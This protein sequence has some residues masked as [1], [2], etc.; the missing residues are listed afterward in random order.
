MN[1]LSTIVVPEQRN[2]RITRLSETL[3]TLKTEFIGL[4]SIIDQIGEAIS[5]WYITP[6]I[7]SRPVVVSLWGMTG[8][9]KSSVVHRL[10]ELL[11]LGN[12]AM[13]FDCGQCAN[14]NKDI[15]NMICQTLGLEDDDASK[16]DR[17]F[18]TFV[19]D[20]FQYAR[21]IDEEGHE[22]L[23]PSLRP[24]WALLDSGIID[25]TDQY[26][27]EFVRLCEF[28]EDLEPITVQYPQIRVKGNRV[29]DP[30][31]VKIILETM[32]FLHYSGREIPGILTENEEFSECYG[33]G[34]KNDDDERPN[35]YRPLDLLDQ[36]CLRAIVKKM[37]EV[38]LGSGQAVAKQIFSNDWTISELFQ[39]LADIRNSVAR[40]KK[41]DCHKAL[42]FVIGNLDEAFQV[43]DDTNP[44]LD[45][46]MFY[47]ITN[48]VTIS[49]MKNALAQRFR[50]E[51][52]ARLGNNLIKYP[53]LQKSSFQKIIKKEV[54]RI[55]EEF[56]K[57]SGLKFNVETNL[58]DLLYAEGV[59]PTQG[60]R[61]IFTTITSILTPYLSKILLEMKPE[62]KEVVIFIDPTDEALKKDFKV[63]KVRIAIK[64]DKD[65]GQTHIYTHN[66][67]LGALRNP[68]SRRKRYICSVHEAGHAIAFAWRTGNAPSNIIS[69]STDHG[70]FC[71]TYD[72]EKEGEI[73][74]RR[75]IDNNTIIS[76]AGYL[77][78]KVIYGDR[79]E[80]CLLG[81]SADI[82][83]FWQDFSTAAYSIGYFK[84]FAFV[85]GNVES[86]PTN[87]L[88]ISNINEQIVNY[89]DGTKFTNIQLPLSAAIRKRFEDLEEETYQML[90][91]EKKLLKKLALELGERGSMGEETFMEYVLQYGSTLTKESMEETHNKYNPDYYLAVLKEEEE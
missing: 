30:N 37:N 6:E 26:N 42:V 56:E 27:Y 84:P 31:D 24:I 14:D 88:G 36:R 11:G 39:L 9:G 69:V 13:Y 73:D 52:V 67:V 50:A 44:D 35:P 3:A 20:E 5:S 66:L 43:E 55:G 68:E 76:L 64:F 86:G 1:N 46:D 63:E 38:E 12:T 28:I 58:L 61:P 83:E 74:S 21:T 81:A 15:P 33:D 90:R 47:D 41:L 22:D 17:D 23:K 54:N 19:F 75:D 80:M 48:R 40:P 59:Y 8:T 34:G 2:D 60:V 71:S 45:A 87:R 4:D 49:D 70:G 85:D 78:E 82:G 53:V 32:G 72:K 29:N 18:E 91:H 57:I 7:I 25:M 62:N 77:A 51:Q 16:W 89:Y 10:I 79:P 65:L